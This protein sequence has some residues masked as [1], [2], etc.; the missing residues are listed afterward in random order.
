MD[1]LV[2]RVRQRCQVLAWATAEHGLIALP[3]EEVQML[4][5]IADAADALWE[6]M[7]PHDYDPHWTKLGQ[8]LRKDMA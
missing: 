2:D 1:D 4:L 6:D 3:N 7:L 5:W 8:L